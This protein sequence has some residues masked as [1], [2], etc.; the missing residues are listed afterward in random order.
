MQK[1]FKAKE[2]LEAQV[3]RAAVAA[4]R[5]YVTEM[6][7]HGCVQAHIDYYRSVLKQSLP[8]PQAR[9][10]TLTRDQYLEVGK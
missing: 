8:K 5:K 1:I 10:I 2:G 7:H 4:C 3:D 9:L 6:H